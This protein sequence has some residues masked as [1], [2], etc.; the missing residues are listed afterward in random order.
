[1]SRFSTR[2]LSRTQ[3]KIRKSKAGEN[4]AGLLRIAAAGPA[5]ETDLKDLFSKTAPNAEVQTVRRKC[6]QCVQWLEPADHR[7]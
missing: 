6:A 4:S 1:V 2:N 3:P 5:V 7:V